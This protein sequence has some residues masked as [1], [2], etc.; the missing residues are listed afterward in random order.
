MKISIKSRNEQRGSLL[1]VA[2]CLCAAIAIFLVSYLQLSTTTMRLANRALYMGAAMNLAENGLEQGVYSLNKSIAD[3]TYPWASHGWSVINS[4]A[5][6]EQKWTGYTFGQGATGQVQVYVTDYASGT[7]TAPTVISRSQITLPDNSGTTI[8]KWVKVQLRKTSKFSNGLVARNSITFNGNNASVDSWN[9]A[10]D[11]SGSPR[12][13][14]AAYSASVRRDNGSVGSVS[15]ATNAINVGNADIWGYA[16][17]GGAQ[18]NVGSNGTI[19]S[20]NNPQGTIDSNRIST[21]F[22]SSF[23]AVTVPTTSTDSSGNAFTITYNTYS[24]SSGVIKTDTSLPRATDAKAADGVYYIQAD[25]FTKG[26]LTITDKVVLVFTNTSTDIGISG[27]DGITINSGASL[28]IYGPGA[29]TITGQG[30][31][32]G[33]TTTATAQQPIN[34]QIYG[35]AVSPSTQNI[36]IKGNG[37]LSGVVYAPQGNLTIDG[38]GDVMGSMVGNTISISGNASFHYD[39]SLGNFGGNNPYRVSNWTEL[40]SNTDRNTYRSLFTGW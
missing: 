39:E 21:D 12:I 9:S 2:L 34:C 37:A 5:D 32:N 36:E 3:S 31:A 7:G 11:N 33:G 27:Q 28:K 38:N 35:T 15:V 18:P 40:T 1:I 10:Y 22:T 23:D 19:A 20:F 29:M 13:S 17:T 14:P 4:G 6:A 30:I 16:S 24:T 26:M 25:S 8:E